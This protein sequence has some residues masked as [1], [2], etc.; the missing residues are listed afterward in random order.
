[1]NPHGQ[2]SGRGEQI[3]R[4]QGSR[5]CDLGWEEVEGVDV[6]EEMGRRFSWL[7]FSLGLSLNPIMLE[8]RTSITRSERTLMSPRGR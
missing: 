1:M 5:V 8:R 6:E 3:W 7:Y 4:P 2:D